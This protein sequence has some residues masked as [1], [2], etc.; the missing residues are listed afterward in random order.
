[1]NICLW[2]KQNMES[3]TVN[4][5]ELKIKSSSS[6]I[7]SPSISL[8]FLYS[9]TLSLLL[10]ISFPPFFFSISNAK[11]RGFIGK[12]EWETTK[13][14]QNLANQDTFHLLHHLEDKELNQHQL[15]QLSESSSKRVIITKGNLMHRQGRRMPRVF[16]QQ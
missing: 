5:R 3:D 11:R 6:N 1:M 7:S 8:P 13:K 10:V 12:D 16:A 15:K 9:Q 2:E 4:R 14:N